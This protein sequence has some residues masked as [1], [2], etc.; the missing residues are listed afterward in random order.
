MIDPYTIKDTS[1]QVLKDPY[2]V[3]DT[4]ELPT[5]NGKGKDIVVT[6]TKEIVYPK[7]RFSY[8]EQ[9]AFIFDL[10]DIV[11]VE[12]ST[13]VGKTV[14]LIIWVWL[15]A[16]GLQPYNRHGSFAKLGDNIYW[17]APTYR[18][19]KIAF[20]RLSAYAPKR[21][22]KGVHKTDLTITTTLGVTI[23]FRTG[24]SDD[25]L[26]GDDVIAVAID[27]GTRMRPNV[28]TV[29]NSLVTATSGQIK[30]I[31]NVKG[32][33]NWVY[34]LTR[35]ANAL[36]DKRYMTRHVL[37]IKY[38]VNAGYVTQ[39]FV[40][41]VQDL[42]SPEEFDELYNCIPRSGH[43]LLFAH[44]FSEYRPVILDP[45][46]TEHDPT[47]AN[48]ITLDFNNI[49]MTG[50]FCQYTK[51]SLHVLKTYKIS[52][53]SSTEE[54]A[55]KIREDYGHVI[56][57]TNTRITGDPSGHSGT[58]SRAGQGTEYT[59]LCTT[60]N[61]PLSCV[62]APRAHILEKYYR[63]LVNALIK[64]KHYFLYIH[65]VRCKDLI[66]DL[67]TTETNKD[68]KIK[69]TGKNSIDGKPNEDKGHALDGFKYA[70]QT[71]FLDSLLKRYLLSSND[72]LYRDKHKLSEKEL[73][74]NI[75]R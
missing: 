45:V 65:P 18:Q 41:R 23:H 7:L 72:T 32:V 47:L 51:N 44:A 36:E 33:T 75:S 38:A 8:P 3:S 46:R 50:S 4:I 30:I 54:L 60:L 43:V 68:H 52:T 22:I 19:A 64:S 66:E 12:A 71:L 70:V 5:A 61:L 74:K 10:A 11:V 42:L 2:Q 62:I 34:K 26:Y 48:L 28:F 21:F 59:A 17:I 25:S 13:K 37:P 55:R 29:A 69:K 49:P 56:N 58:Y 35:T 14:G 15:I 20:K 24:D 63:M 39:E 6:R 27:E 73:T 57:A 40:N 53:D 1:V 9:E 31:C 16:I 67:E